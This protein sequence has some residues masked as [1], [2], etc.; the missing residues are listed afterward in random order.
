MFPIKPAISCG[1][2]LLAASLHGQDKTL[3]SRVLDFDSKNV[4]LTETLIKFS[5]QQH[6][7]IA[8]EY[9]DRFS[10]DQPIE[11]NIRNKTVREALNAILKN[12]RGYRRRWREGIVEVTN[13]RVLKRADDQLSKVIPVF[14]ISEGTTVQFASALLWLNLQAALDP[15]LK[16]SGVGGDFMGTSSTVKSAKLK[17]QTVRE[18]LRYIVLNSQADGWTVSGPQECLGFTPYCGLW[19]MIEAEPSDPSYKLLL[20]RI[21]KNL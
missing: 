17:N 19:Y 15:S 6:V 10:M 11:V 20:D 14:E 13:T 16:K 5:H 21:R 2:L 18:I 12:G 3:E 8:I 4:G 9:L 7:P 1:L